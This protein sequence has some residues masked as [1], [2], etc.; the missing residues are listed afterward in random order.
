MA[1]S[2]DTTLRELLETWQLSDPVPLAQ[3]D[4]GRLFRVRRH[5]GDLA[6]LK[7]LS[8]AGQRHEAKASEALRNFAGQGAVNLFAASKTAVLMEFCDGPPLADTPT[9]DAAIPVVLDVVSRLHAAP[10][11]ATGNFETLRQRCRA[12]DRALPCADPKSQD[13]IKHAKEL[14]AKLLTTAPETQL[15]HGDVHHA[16]ILQ[17]SARSPATWLAIDPQPVLGERAYDIANI[18]RNPISHRDVIL[19]P[20]RADRL[21]AQAAPHLSLDPNRVIGWAFVHAC[22]ALSWSIEDGD[23]P[24]L[25]HAAAQALFQ[26]QSF[27]SAWF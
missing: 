16:N 25:C 13:L 8:P 9:D 2:S 15:L 19:A 3:T 7:C 6:V 23:D 26:S 1:S 12:F 11:R 22:I 27:K 4:K 20:G 5:T 24:R 14:S 21:V 17:S 18:F 10:K